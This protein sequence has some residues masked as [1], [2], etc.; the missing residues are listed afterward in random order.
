V[1]DE[2]AT[3][4]I[5]SLLCH[6]LSYTFIPSLLRSLILRYFVRINQHDLTP[7][8]DESERADI[9]RVYWERMLYCKT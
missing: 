5:R 3:R 6:E 7:T 9:A 2:A 8:C 1:L 4:R